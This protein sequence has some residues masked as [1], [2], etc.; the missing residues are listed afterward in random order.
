MAKMKMSQFSAEYKEFGKIDD[1]AIMC[2]VLIEAHADMTSA[3]W[4]LY[5]TPSRT[6]CP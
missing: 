5:S 6:G 4:A 1:T 3:F 2:P